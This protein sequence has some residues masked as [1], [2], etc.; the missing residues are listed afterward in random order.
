MDALAG[1][2]PTPEQEAEAYA[3][4]FER[5]AHGVEGASGRQGFIPRVCWECPLFDWDCD[6]D[7]YHR[8]YFCTRNVFFPTR[9][10]TCKVREGEASRRAG[11]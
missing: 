9:T 1:V 8:S 6:S 2:G 3:S 10:G 4:R 11:G 5:N 7:G